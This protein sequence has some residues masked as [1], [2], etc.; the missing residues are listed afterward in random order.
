MAPRTLAQWLDWQ[1]RLHPAG[2]ALGLERVRAV[3]RRMRIDLGGVPVITVAGTNGKGSMVAF[4]EAICRQAGYR[5]GAYTSPHL[6]R[7]NERIRVAGQEV[8]D[9]VLVAAF[10]AVEAA[11][12]DVPLT[13]FEFGTLA[14]LWCFA[15]ARC[16]VLLLEVG[17]GGR[18]DAVNLIDPDCALLGQI[19]LDH[20]DWLGADR[21]AIGREK[22]GIFRSGRPAVCGDPRP[23]ASVRRQAAALGTRLWV[24][25]EDFR[26]H[27]HPSG[28][29]DWHG[30]G[31]ALTD[32][33]TPGLPGLHQYG[34]AAAAIAA[35]RLLGAR[36]PLAG[37]A[38]RRGLGAV[39]LAGRFERLARN[40]EV[41]LD[42]AHN[43]AAAAALADLLAARPVAGRTL[44]VFAALGDKDVPGMVRA[45]ATR[46][47]VWHLAGLD[48]PRGL[49][50]EALRDRMPDDLP[51]RIHAT[52]AAAC[53]AAL[54]EAGADDRI[55]VFGS[56]H[57]LAAAR[58]VLVDILP[59]TEGSE[60]G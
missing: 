2:I 16:E 34:N 27:R 31:G 39:R 29:W 12:A 32:L 6:Y 8:E 9:R 21:E 50:A 20:A 33:P 15:R 44:G 57:T 41:I 60:D 23:P 58:P 5:T 40:P 52:V 45:L 59:A 47:D 42:V 7:Y 4:L 26:V 28:R 10:E 54:A 11:R 22:A 48:H 36:L 49:R 53:H 55:L 17:L 24:A 14:A 37:E 56:F 19:A 25:G 13:Y 1:S 30:P 51:V 46:V 43:P 35:C 3:W 38:V 18:L